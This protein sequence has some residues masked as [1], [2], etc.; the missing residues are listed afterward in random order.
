MQTKQS[1]F[2][3]DNTELEKIFNDLVQQWLTETRGISS[4][5]Q[6]S[7]HSAYQQIIGMGKDAIPLLLREIERRS[8]HWF[9]ALKSISR[10]DP[11]APEQRGKIKE[12]THAWLD[13]GKNQGYTW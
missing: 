10:E 13:W 4:I 2:N 3:P 11:V 6:M 5:N 8:G 7:M 1:T 9:W 12:M